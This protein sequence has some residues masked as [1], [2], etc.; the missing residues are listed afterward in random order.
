MSPVTFATAPA[1]RAS[2]VRKMLAVIAFA[3]L[4]IRN[5]HSGAFRG[6]YTPE[7]APWGVEIVECQRWPHVRTVDVVGPPQVGKTFHAVELPVA[8]DLWEAHETVFYMN[9][10]ADNALN[11]WSA[12]LEPTMRADPVLRQQELARMDGGRWAERHFRD[13]GLLYSAGPESA[14]ALAQREARIIRCSELEKTKAAIGNEASSY[15]LARDR[16]AAYPQTSLVTSDCTVTVREGLSWVRFAQGDRSRPFIPCAGCGYYAMPA[17]ERHLE[18]PDLGVTIDDVHLLE[19]PEMAAASPAAA[20]ELATFTCRACGYVFTNR[21]YRAALRAL[22]WVPLGCRVIRHDDAKLHPIPTVSWLDDLVKWA[23]LQL[24]NPDVVNGL[25]DPDDPPH[26]AGPRLPD[27]VELDW[28]QESAA[29]GDEQTLPGLR[30][31]PRKSSNRSFWLW[32]M[33]S[34]KYTIGQ[35]A[36]EIVAGDL[37]AETG[38]KR[39]DYKNCTQKTLVLPYEEPVGVGAEDLAERVVLMAVGDLPRGQAPADTVAVTSGIDVNEDAVRAVKRAWT[40]DGK[41]YLIDHRAE[42]TG[43]TQ[44]KEQAGRRRDAADPH[45]AA[46]RTRAIYDALDKIW[47]WLASG[48]HL[49]LAYLDSGFLADEIYQWCDGKSFE[50]IRPCKGFGTVAPGRRRFGHLAGSWTESCEK[51]ATECRDIRGRPLRHQYYEPTDARRM[52]RLDADHWKK[53]VHAGIR[54]WSVRAK[55]AQFKAEDKVAAPWFFLHAGVAINDDYVPQVVAERW[56]EWTNPRTGFKERGWKEYH[57]ENHY[58]DAEAYAFAA[59]AA[60]GVQIGAFDA[61]IPRKHKKPKHGVV[62]RVGR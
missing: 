44:Y 30:N 43:L 59:A 34:P 51:R 55:A 40:S 57:G 47:H 52:M 54:L 20:D 10:S 42:F 2:Q 41:S 9:G 31:D 15:A 17:H 3:M 4:R 29:A 23:A 48:P 24:S 14:A 38:D 7:T 39:D 12:R 61:G 49:T 56:E 26:W 13:G 22:V 45:F 60:C 6:M 11:I 21:E 27:G 33:C 58:L 16:A 46:T 53:E 36:R 37:G 8:F 35:V 18:E 1:R 19:I 5:V 32:R 50:R 25:T 28:R 62:G